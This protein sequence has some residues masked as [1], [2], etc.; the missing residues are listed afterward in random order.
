MLPRALALIAVAFL[1]LTHGAGVAQDIEIIIG[2][3][4]E[5]CWD[6]CNLHYGHKIAYDGW[7]RD[8]AEAWFPGCVS[9]CDC[10]ESG[11]SVCEEQH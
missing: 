3:P 4:G 9:T 6:R 1:T 10:M 2:N 11:A 5:S 8:M 7:T